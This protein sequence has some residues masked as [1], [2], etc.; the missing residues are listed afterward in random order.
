[1]L[2]P[3]GTRPEIIK[4]TPVVRVLRDRG[5]DVRVVAT[6]QHY[7]S[8]LAE[9]FFEGLGLMP[10][11][12]WPPAGD[13]DSRLGGLLT[14]A[15][16]ELSQHHPRPDIV[17]VLGDTDTVP[18]FCLAAR[19]YG[20]PV[21]HLEAGL[22]SLNPTSMEE[23]NRR[24][25]AAC[26]SLHLPPTE[27]AQEFLLEEGVDPNRVRVVGNPIV[28][29]L[30]G[31]GIE[32]RPFEQRSG[33]V[34]TAHRRTN[35]DVP[36]RLEALVGIVCSLAERMGPVTFPLHP[37]TGVRLD[38][39]GLRPRLEAA[40][41]HIIAPLPYREMLELMVRS[42]LVVTDS[43]GLQEEASWLGIPVVVLRRSTPRWE[44]V[45]IGA[46][47]LVGLDPAMALAEA[48][49]LAEPEMQRLVAALPCPY[50]DGHTAERV[51]SILEEPGIHRLLQLDEPDLRGYCPVVP[52]G[53]LVADR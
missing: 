6:G 25:A 9:V 36:E 15:E 5:F 40:G 50:G 14:R 12:R 46:A 11:E 38:E 48:D 29:V 2:V 16:E 24:V 18:V 17:L 3:L 8:E 31:L 28:D 41:V 52:V 33:V 26:S 47:T 39:A 7:D 10:D 43:G 23:V 53:D 42:R 13:R 51:A 44:G 45:A 27:V 30:E 21:V 22:R 1:M 34:V 20:V 19:R 4:L 32:R 37:R 35:V 49:R